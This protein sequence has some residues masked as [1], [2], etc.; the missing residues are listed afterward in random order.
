MRQKLG[1]VWMEILPV[2][3]RKILLAQKQSP[4][5]G[6]FSSVFNV[7]SEKLVCLQSGF[8]FM[9][10]SAFRPGFACNKNRVPV[11]D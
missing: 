7:K 4:L 9:V 1:F 6:S 10:T 3:I 5:P 2:F 11:P 8:P